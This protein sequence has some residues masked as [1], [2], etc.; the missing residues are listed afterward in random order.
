MSELSRRSWVRAARASLI[1]VSAV[2]IAQ[3]A[4]PP[5]DLAVQSVS[6][7]QKQQALMFDDFNGPA[8][9]PPNPQWW[10]Y[11]TGG[12]GWGNGESQ[13]YTS[14][15]SNVR[16]DGAGHLVIEA[17]NDGGEYTSA[18][19]TTQGRTS[20]L[21]GRAEARAKLP[22]GSGMHPAFWL[23]GTDLG[24]VG[25]PDSGEIDVVETIGGADQLYS[26]V[27]GP[28]TSGGDWQAGPT[29]DVAN[30]FVDDFH[31]YWV[32]KAP[33]R[34]TFGVDGQITGAVTAAGLPPDERWVFDKPFFLLLNVAVGGEWPGP[35]D[36]S[37]PFPA[38]MVVDWVR[39]TDD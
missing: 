31:T 22:R 27:I 38:A 23:L 37:T 35:P 3:A 1:G 16:L 12:G 21:Y 7:Y 29:T 2:L 6:S 5:T 20:L 28:R 36:S 32:E 17:R 30:T 11:D 9:A 15:P 10:S 18:R 34:V 8:W 13:T 26:S 24:V 19:V 25:W 39:V 4:A 14:A 33:G